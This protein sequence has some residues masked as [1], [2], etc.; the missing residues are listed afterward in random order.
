[1]QARYDHGSGRCVALDPN[2]GINGPQW[3]NDCV[4]QAKDGWYD[5]DPVTNNIVISHNPYKSNH[6]EG[7]GY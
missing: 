2:V 7:R 4:A 5:V 1:M 3:W 6:A